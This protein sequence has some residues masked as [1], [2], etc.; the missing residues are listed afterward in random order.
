MLL[1][2]V[3]LHTSK[4]VFSWETFNPKAFRGYYR[5]EFQQY[6]CTGTSETFLLFSRKV[7]E[8]IAF[9]R[10]EPAENKIFQQTFL[11]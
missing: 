9:L 7:V 2:L 4:R 6:S 11:V 10:L 1:V 3:H 5:T 8:D